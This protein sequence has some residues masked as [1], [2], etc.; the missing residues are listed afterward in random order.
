MGRQTPKIS[1]NSFAK[2]FKPDA[3]Q[4]R[5]TGALIDFLE[6]A[7]YIL[8]KE[9]FA[10]GEAVDLDQSL[11]EKTILWGVGSNWVVENLRCYKP[12]EHSIKQISEI[13]TDLQYLFFNNALDAMHQERTSTP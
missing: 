12:K 10:L 7:N 5:L 8:V 2:D 11:I 6:V 9:A 1:N 13:D 4:K 3:K